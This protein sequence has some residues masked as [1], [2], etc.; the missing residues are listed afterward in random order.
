ME[1]R[2]YTRQQ[3]GSAFMLVTLEKKRDAHLTKDIAMIIFD[4]AVP[5]VTPA[6]RPK[7][8][9]CRGKRNCTRMHFGDE[10]IGGPPMSSPCTIS[11]RYALVQLIGVRNLHIFTSFGEYSIEHM[12]NQPDVITNK[13]RNGAWCVLHYVMFIRRYAD[14]LSM[15]DMCGDSCVNVSDTRALEENCF[16]MSTEWWTL[17]DS[18]LYRKDKDMAMKLIRRGAV[19]RSKHNTFEK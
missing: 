10:L 8:C 1:F 12:R 3:L 9:E 4:M 15:L 6:G 5:R 16:E 18:A 13:P 7:I 14:V 11:D 17:L 19:V 2:W